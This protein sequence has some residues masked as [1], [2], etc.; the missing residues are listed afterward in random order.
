MDEL[1]SRQ[2]VHDT[3]LIEYGNNELHPE[4]MPGT[5]LPTF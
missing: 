1:V 2:T 5:I 4:V 3:V